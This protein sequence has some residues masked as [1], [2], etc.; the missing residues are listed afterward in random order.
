MMGERESEKDA[1]KALPGQQQRLAGE[2]MGA[3]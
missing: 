2:K 3:S 1:K